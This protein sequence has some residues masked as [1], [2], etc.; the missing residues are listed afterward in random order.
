[1]RVRY[2]VYFDRARMYVGYAQFFIILAMFFDPY[3]DTRFGEWFYQWWFLTIPIFI[4]IFLFS[5]LALGYFDKRYIRP[6]E[7][8]ELIST[9]P[10]W[11]DMYNKIKDIHNKINKDEEL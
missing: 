11:M 10:L 4:L 9:N 8:E 1:M 2:K 7:Q 5:C 3:K 6:K